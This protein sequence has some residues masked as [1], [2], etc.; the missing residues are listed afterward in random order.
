MPESSSSENTG[1]NVEFQSLHELNDDYLL[2][3]FV[4]AGFSTYIDRVYLLQQVRL[5]ATKKGIYPILSYHPNIYLVPSKENNLSNKEKP[6]S[7]VKYFNDG[8]YF[9]NFCCLRNET[10]D[11]LKS[12]MSESKSVLIV[13]TPF[14]GKTSLSQLL[15]D[16]LLNIEKVNSYLINFCFSTNNERTLSISQRPNKN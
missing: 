6:G 7:V 15:H 4:E 3:L 8:F 9:T 2:A 14:T 1:G 11:E 16:N 10:V 5:S 12:K 13:S